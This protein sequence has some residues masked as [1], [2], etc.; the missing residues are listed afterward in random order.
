[1]DILRISRTFEKFMRLKSKG[2]TKRQLS[3]NPEPRFGLTLLFKLRK[4]VPNPFSVCFF[5]G[6]NQNTDGQ[7]G[8]SVINGT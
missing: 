7:K 6:K 5:I 3:M 8:V 4:Y 1:M 2:D